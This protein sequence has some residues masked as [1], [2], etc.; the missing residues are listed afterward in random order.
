MEGRKRQK[1]EDLVREK[2]LVR[3]KDLEAETEVPTGKGRA[4]EGRHVN[5]RRAGTE[6]AG[7]RTMLHPSPFSAIHLMMTTQALTP[8]T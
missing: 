2:D 3:G 8:R 6:T 5:A 1:G 4:V 7:G